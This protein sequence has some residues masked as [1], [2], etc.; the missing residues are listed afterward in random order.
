MKLHLKYV[1]NKFIWTLPPIPNADSPRE[2]RAK[3]LKTSSMKDVAS[4]AGSPKTD[5]VKCLRIYDVY[6]VPAT[7]L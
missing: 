3:K 7:S 2:E 5:V 1:I 4:I 6:T